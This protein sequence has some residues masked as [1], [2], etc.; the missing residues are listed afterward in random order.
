MSASLMERLV[1]NRPVRHM[2][3]RVFGR[4]AC[5]RVRPLDS[6]HVAEVQRQ[7]L[8]RPIRLGQPPRFGRDHAFER[9][10]T[11]RDYQQRV[12]LRDYE[13]FSKAYW[14]PAFPRLDDVTWPGPIPYFAL[15]SGTTSGSTKYIPVSPT[16]VAS[17]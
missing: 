17:N 6:C 1:A 16:M 14:Q 7:T 11:V 13:A 9:L 2:A 10:R 8:R 4:Y 15:S 5:H 12:P 3:D